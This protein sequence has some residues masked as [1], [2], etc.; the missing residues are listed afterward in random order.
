MKRLL[1]LA[2]M[3][4]LARP[5]IAQVLPVSPQTVTTIDAGVQCSTPRS[6]ASS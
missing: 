5:M 2:L 1:L 4:A 6:C 3:L